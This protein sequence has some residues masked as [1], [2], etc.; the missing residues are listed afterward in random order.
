M[1]IAMATAAIAV[2]PTIAIANV[3]NGDSGSPRRDQETRTLDI[4]RMEMHRLQQL[5]KKL[6]KIRYGQRGGGG[7]GGGGGRGR[8]RGGGRGS[9]SGRGGGRESRG[10]REGGRERIEGGRERREGGRE[11]REGGRERREGGGNIYINL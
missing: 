10:R 4:V 7:G 2:A 9:G 5:K 1:Q 6:L 11:R 8:G 3:A